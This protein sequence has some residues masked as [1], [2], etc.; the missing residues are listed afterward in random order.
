M[1]ELIGKEGE[2]FANDIIYRGVLVECGETD[3]HLQAE[4]GYIIIPMD[5]VLEIKAAN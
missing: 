5:S 3:V 4:T 2:V 1:Q